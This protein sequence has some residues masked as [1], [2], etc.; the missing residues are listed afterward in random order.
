MRST[1]FSAPQTTQTRALKYTEEQIRNMPEKE[2]RRVFDDPD[3]IK[4]C[5]FYYSEQSA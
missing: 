1:G 5:E 4:A 3:Y 2:R